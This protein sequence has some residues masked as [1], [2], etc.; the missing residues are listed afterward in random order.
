MP[1]SFIYQS[2]LASY[3]RT[4]QLETI[5]GIKAENIG[6]YRRLVYNTVDDM[7]Q[8]AYPLT[9]DL[10]EEE[11]WN[12]LVAAFFRDHPCQSPQVWYM[13]KELIVYLDAMAHPLKVKY[14]F[15]MELLNFEWT[16]VEIFMME[17][18]VVS[19]RQAGNILVDKLI[20]NPEHKLLNFNYPVHQKRAGEIA[21]GDYG[22]YFLVAHRN[23]DGDVVFT[24]LSPALFSMLEFIESAPASLADIR[25]EF[26]E[27][28]G[29]F[30]SKD[31]ETA[32][33]F[34]LSDAL[35]SQLIAGFAS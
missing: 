1:D 12:E 20:I 2:I 11:E 24:S 29:I 3:C 5:P 30:L 17:D 28:Y 34:F 31:D 10:L 19:A 7:L 14:S 35:Q 16:E 18:K 22:Q 27:E 21:A 8:N 9:K 26:L 6:Q 13:P 15:I 25:N 33:Q 4:G 23:K 32:I